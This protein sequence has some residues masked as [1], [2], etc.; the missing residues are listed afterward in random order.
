[1]TKRA[2]RTG[3]LRCAG[4]WRAKYGHPL[5]AGLS[6]VDWRQLRCRTTPAPRRDPTL[7]SPAQ[8]EISCCKG[9]VP[10]QDAPTEMSAP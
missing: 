8:L 10:W 3:A 9:K 1:M 7:D 6:C 4:D 5:Y 2:K